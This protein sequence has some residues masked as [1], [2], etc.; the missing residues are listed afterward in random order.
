[1]ACRGPKNQNTLMARVVEAVFQLRRVT[2]PGI[3]AEAVLEEY[4]LL[5]PAFPVTLASLT[6]T[7]LAG[8]KRGLFSRCEFP[9]FSGVY[10]FGFNRDMAA[11]NPRNREF[12]MPLF[13]DT[14]RSGSGYSCG[15]TVGCPK[16]L[17]L[18]GGGGGCCPAP[19]SPFQP[20]LARTRDL[21]CCQPPLGS[22]SV[23]SLVV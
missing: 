15:C 4:N 7:L 21:S 5:F 17:V 16:G 18:G 12:G 11:L 10:Y 6:A 13:I 8:A 3:S 22:A 1:M 20:P 23:D 9:A 14:T 19:T 2:F